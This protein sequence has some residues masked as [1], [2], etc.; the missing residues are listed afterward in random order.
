M[1]ALS[2]TMANTA[3]APTWNGIWDEIYRSRPWGKYPK[4]ELIRFVARNYYAV[5]DR[6]AV[7]FLDLGCGFGSSTWFL[8]R[9]GFSVDAI[10]GS[11]V[12]IERL[13]K[14]MREENLRA[15]LIAGDIVDLPYPARSF[16]CVVDIACLMCNEPEGTRRI[17]DGVFD[18]LK[19][20]GK[21]FSISATPSSWGAKSGKPV[22][23]STYRDLTEGPFAN[24]GTVRFSSEQQ[25]KELYSK[26][27]DL[28][29]GL[30]EY[31]IGDRSRLVSH[32]VI[33]GTKT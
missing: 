25:I 33:E 8:A 11:A 7:R 31:S 1:K 28:V 18:R 13:S 3:A 14:R 26:F 22:A 30:S 4:E 20:G 17:L 16:D 15:R 5:P 27:S 10:D 32:W 19:P 24:T 12:I 9:E 29:I 23:D 2:T 21:L 6:S